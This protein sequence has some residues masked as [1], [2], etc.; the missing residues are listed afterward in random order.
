MNHIEQVIIKVKMHFLRRP[1][2][3]P[4]LRGIE[5]KK[6]NLEDPPLADITPAVALTPR[7]RKQASASNAQN[8]MVNLR[9]QIHP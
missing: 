8:G 6:S 3:T 1:Y 7:P 9:Y 2:S 5:S 4:K